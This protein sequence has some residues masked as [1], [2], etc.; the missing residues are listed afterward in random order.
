[1]KDI[2]S[3]ILADFLDP[4]VV[5]N[6][7]REVVFL[8]CA[9]Q[10]L[11][12]EALK[13]GDPC[14][15]CSET[16]IITEANKEG[17]RRP[18]C[19][20]AA[21]I[22]KQTPILLKTR[23]PIGA[24]L[25]LSAISIRD[26][27]HEKVGCLLHITEH[28]ELLAHPVMEQQMATLSSILENFPQPFFM[29]DPFLVVTHINDHMEELTGYSRGEVVGRM[30]CGELLNTI[31]C[32]TCDCVLKQVME[33]KKP[34]SGLRRVV[35]DRQGREVPVSVS[36]SIITDSEGRVIG[37]F[38]AVRDITPVVEAEQKLDL[39]TQLTQEG[40]LMA[41]ENHRVI[42][43]N[44]RMMEIL[45]T[46]RS[47]ILGMHLGEV[48]SSQHLHMAQELVSL[49]DRDLQQETRFCSILDKPASEGHVP[50]VFETC[51]AVSRL[52]AK[53]ITCLY[54][55]D[56]T[57]RIL[58]ER[59]LQKTNAFLTN[60]IQ[61]SVD[62]IVVVDKKGV[63]LIF[64]EGAERILGYKA[65]EMI[66]NPENFRRFY[67]LQEATEMMR[68]MRSDEY[69]PADKLNTSRITF[70]NKQ[71]EEVPVNFSATIIRERGEEV[72]SVGIF[73]DLREILKVHR[74]LEAVQSQLVHTEKIA[75]L[76]RMAAGVAHEINNPL[77][78]ILIYAELLQRDLAADDA[79]RENLEV[80][81]TQTMRCQQIVNR[82]LDF[83][84]QTLGQKKLFDV[85]D[86]IHRCT[87]LISHQAFFLNIKVVEH[88]DPLLPQ[89]VGDPGQLQQVF[90]N[91]LLNA[92]DA[93][94]GQGR[95][96]IASRPTPR[97]DGIILTFTDTGPGIPVEI[98]DKIFEPFFTTKPPGKGTGL[99]LSIVYGVMQ[100]HGGT[101]EADSSPGEG[102]TF[103]IRL[104]LD[105]QENGVTM[106]FEE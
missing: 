71:G 77:A 3:S 73:T 97:E 51:M 63:P 60:I 104:P 93:M 38:E 61:S 79:H 23:W 11:F 19:P 57:S 64:N 66:G 103:T 39:L 70:I 29:V 35:R 12:G 100:R 88:L 28:K 106:E 37:G 26:D 45:N 72:G 67:P 21:G 92:A 55:R 86:V 83:S 2:F 90:T 87:E 91:L 82:L 9:A 69:G 98:R 32:N 36:A 25:S 14:P 53:T 84:R 10:K 4:V 13:P 6:H 49:V 33:R 59:E 22:L 101:I 43:A 99:G 76:G 94:N 65:E 7:R 47:R 41:D 52:G 54:L 96:T 16:P 102:T 105:S 50:R 8:N 15:L 20:Q 42:F 31:Q 34:L 80:I 27:G 62:G 18:Q 89:I 81:V 24:P 68:R 95:I 5:A 46:P 56:L 48:L 30:T 17:L 75:S 58:I 1:M 85:N 44:T 40:L 74:E 78:G